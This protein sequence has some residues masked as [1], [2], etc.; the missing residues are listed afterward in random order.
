MDAQQ[1]YQGISEHYSNVALSNDSARSC[2]IAQAF[3]YS[4]NDLEAAPQANLGLSCGNP[5]AIAGLREVY[6]PHAGL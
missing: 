6:L 4:L 5:L 1:L 3:G 2:R